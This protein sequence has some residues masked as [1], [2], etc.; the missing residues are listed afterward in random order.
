MS[1]LVQTAVRLAWPGGGYVR[2]LSR[3]LNVSLRHAKRLASGQ[4]T[5]R[6]RAPMMDALIERLGEVI[7]EAQQIREQLKGGRDLEAA[8]GSGGGG[9]VRPST[10]RGGVHTSGPPSGEVGAG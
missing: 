3:E 2:W 5:E 1:A 8:Q 4:V 6:Q 10:H 7:E 9:G